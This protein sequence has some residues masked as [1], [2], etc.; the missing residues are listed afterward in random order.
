[1]H[2][3]R[4]AIAVVSAAQVLSSSSRFPRLRQLG[5]LLFPPDDLYTPLAIVPADLSEKRPVE[6]EYRHRYPGRHSLDLD[7]PAPRSVGVPWAGLG[8]L[9]CEAT[10][11]DSG[12]RHIE[13]HGTPGSPYWRADGW[14]VSL[15]E[16]SVPG[17][18][19]LSSTIRCRVSCSSGGVEFAREF[20]VHRFVVKKRSEK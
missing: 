12:G 16:Y 13:A 19:A 5:Q 11:T 6:F 18:M 9:H 3:S 8:A 17:E 4:F 20:P 7:V 10:C 2:K 14:G 15:I 1:V